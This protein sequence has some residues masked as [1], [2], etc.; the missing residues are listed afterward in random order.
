MKARGSDMPLMPTQAFL[1]QN[2]PDF[3]SASE[4]SMLAEMYLSDTSERTAMARIIHLLQELDV[5][6][7]GERHDP[8]KADAEQRLRDTLVPRCGLSFETVFDKLKTFCSGDHVAG[9]RKVDV[10]VFKRLAAVYEPLK[11]ETCG[12]LPTKLLVRLSSV[13]NRFYRSVA[14]RSDL[15]LSEYSEGSAART[16][17]SRNYTYH[18]DIDRLLAFTNVNADASIHDWKRGWTESFDPEPTTSALTRV[19]G[20]GSGASTLSAVVEE[21]D[22]KGDEE[23]EKASDESIRYDGISHEEAA[24]LALFEATKRRG[25]YSP[26]QLS[27]LNATYE[28]HV[29]EIGSVVLPEWFVPSYEVELGDYISQGSF[30]AVYRGKWFDTDVVI[31]TLLSNTPEQRQA[32]MKEAQIWFMLNHPNVVRL[33]GACHVGMRPFF[34]CEN[35]EEGTLERYL[36]QNGR[37]H[38]VWVRLHQAALGL[39]YLHDRGVV[40]GDLKGNNILVGANM[41]AML[42]DFGLSEL[43]REQDAT[44]GISARGAYR[45]KAPECLNGVRPSYASDVFSFGMCIVEAVSGEYP[46]GA[47]LLDA[48]VAHYV[49]RGGLPERPE[50]FG[51]DAWELVTRM[52]CFDPSA[53]ID[54]TLVVQNLATLRDTS[55]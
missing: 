42:I 4:W 44:N 53:R 8:F 33:C 16:I 12:S 38:W 52:C 40:H 21:D 3:V 50:A 20:D 26:R 30:G 51:D 24:V 49:K 19:A 54:M 5:P 36:A 41:E 14:T 35:A 31:K 55:K 34:V 7:F 39:Q 22:S 46:W 43:M 10:R 23:E 45:W 2:R 9:L 11:D 27:A 6:L 15:S 37:E 47:T 1:E 17:A 29:R 18:L 13:I 28:R 48:A 32:F 25:A